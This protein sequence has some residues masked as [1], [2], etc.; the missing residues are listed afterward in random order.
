VAIIAV[1]S[2]LHI[3]S[4]VALCPP[5]FEIHSGRA[6]ETQVVEATKAQMWLWASWCD[7]WRYV[8]QLASEGGE[9]KKHRIIVI[10]LGDVIEGNHHASNQNIP[11]IQDQ[12]AVAMQILQPVKDMSDAFFGVMGT[13]AHAGTNNDTEHGIYRTL[14]ATEY[15]YQLTLNID[16]VLIDAAHHSAAPGINPLMR[17]LADYPAS[18]RPNYILRGHRHVIVDTGANHPDTRMI[19]CP[20]WQLKTSYGWR[21][22]QR[23]RADIGGLIINR[24]IMDMSR[25]RY[26]AQPDE[27]RI[28]NA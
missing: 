25:S 2:D 28:I 9:K 3:G 15:D 12:V 26:Q 13:E 4:S 16:G 18:S 10:C 21:V 1:I 27:R 5:K 20:S 17:I 24:G 7:Y 14:E 6:D 23:R 22:D 11:E 8:W 19:T